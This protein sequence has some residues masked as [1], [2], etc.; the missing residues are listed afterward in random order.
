MTAKKIS[1]ILIIV[2]AI[3]AAVVATGL[4]AGYVMQAW[5][6]SYWV[7]LTAKNLVDYV[8]TIEKGDANENNG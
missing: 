7:T 4:I 5:I 6:V 3:I 2:L 8:G 1:A